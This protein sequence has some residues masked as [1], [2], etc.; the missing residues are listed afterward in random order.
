[1]TLPMSDSEVAARVLKHIAEGTTDVG[2]E[3]WHE[4]VEN[5]RSH[6][7]FEAEIT[8]LRRFPTAFCPS[9]ALPEKGSYV[10]REAAGVPILAVRGQDGKVRAFRNACR[11][12]G[13]SLA[14][15]AGCTKAFRCRYHGWTYG[16]DG[17][18]RQVPHE[19]GFPG[20]DKS[21]HGLVPVK[22]EERGGLIFVT[23]DGADNALEELPDLIAHDQLL[24]D[25]VDREVGANWK[26]FLEGFLEGYHIRATHPETFLPYGFDNLTVL[27]TFGRNSRITFPFKRIQKLTDVPPARRSVLGLVTYVYHLFPNALVTILSSHTNLVILEPMS[28]EKTRLVMYSLTNAGQGGGEETLAAAKRDAEFVGNTGAAEDRAV[29]AAIQKG[30][31]SKAN[32][33][34]TFGHYESLIIHFHKTLRAALATSGGSAAPCWA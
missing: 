12:R 3:V 5:Y 30:I 13:M 32:T 18:L 28:L 1:M 11:H 31:A 15:G 16:L 23:Q 6:A 33:H 14:D 27:E 29:V 4:P 20:L 10:A 26:I 9:A 22:T 7:R 25:T 2:P 19:Q 24:Y 34:F 8:M 17:A 21:T